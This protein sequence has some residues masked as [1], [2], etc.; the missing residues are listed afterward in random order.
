MREKTKPESLH[1][2]HFQN[3]FISEVVRFCGLW[4]RK[5]WFQ[6]ALDFEQIS[7]MLFAQKLWPRAT[8]ETL[9]LSCLYTM[10]HET[11]LLTLY[12]NACYLQYF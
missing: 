10:M 11:L 6:F 9:N 7:S 12:S 1:N 8:A 3:I 5:L 4:S 2:L